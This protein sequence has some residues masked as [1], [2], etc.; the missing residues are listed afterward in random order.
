MVLQSCLEYNL[1]DLFHWPNK[2]FHGFIY[3][4]SN[5]LHICSLS[6]LLF[7]MICPKFGEV[8]Y[9][10]RVE[11]IQDLRFE[12]ATSRIKAT[13]DGEYIIASG[14]CCFSFFIFIIHLSLMRR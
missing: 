4:H 1:I 6:L 11:L 7:L 13:P 12:T 3:C 10:Q 8:D 2:I 5:K 9:M 14:E